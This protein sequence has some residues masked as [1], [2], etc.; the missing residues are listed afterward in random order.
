MSSPNKILT[1]FIG[2][3][4]TVIIF[5]E[6]GH[7]GSGSDLA[8]LIAAGL[9][10]LML[11]EGSA[12]KSGLSLGRHAHGLFLPAAHGLSLESFPYGRS[13]GFGFPGLHA[14]NFAPMFG[15][16]RYH[17]ANLDPMALPGPKFNKGMELN[18]PYGRNFGL[19]PP[20]P[21]MFRQNNKPNPMNDHFDIVRNIIQRE[22]ENIAPHHTEP[23]NEP[24]FNPENREFF[25]FDQEDKPPAD[26]RKNQ[27]IN[28]MP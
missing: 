15:G 21:E 18:L 6:A 13:V 19:Y 3:L 12:S 7:H 9:I 17:L 23:Q 16:L 8:T 14:F 11:K 1:I 28:Q 27:R 2:F 10:T 24:P 25:N 4:T 20:L 26:H 22:R 5:V